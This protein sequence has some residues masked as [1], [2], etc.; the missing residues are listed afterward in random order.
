MAKVKTESVRAREARLKAQ[1]VEVAAAEAAGVEAAHAAEAARVEAASKKA[2]RIAPKPKRPRFVRAEKADRP[3][4]A[5]ALPPPASTPSGRLL[6]KA[7]KPAPKVAA[8]GPNRGPAVPH[9]KR[10]IRHEG[11]SRK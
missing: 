1:A 4:D 10:Q 11:V 9:D 3:A 5:G 7:A 2:E 6:S 8:A